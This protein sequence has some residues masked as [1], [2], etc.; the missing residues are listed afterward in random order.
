MRKA[1]C[2]C[3]TRNY[4]EKVIPSLN[5]MLY[6][7]KIDT[8][9]IL[10]EDDDMPFPVP[11]CVKVINVSD[12]EYFK[13]TGINY[14]NPWSY[15]VMMRGALADI[16]EDE[17]QVLSID[18]DTIINEDISP[19][20][21]YDLTG[22]YLAGARE[23]ELSCLHCQIY[24][25]FGVVML[26]LKELR[27]MLPSGFAMWEEL[28]WWMNNVQVKYIEQDTHN[29]LCAGKILEI[30]SDWNVTSDPVEEDDWVRTLPTEHVR[31]RHYAGES[32]WWDYPEVEKWK[33]GRVKSDGT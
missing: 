28:V 20:W 30:P 29:K 5:S 31:I 23:L 4:Y 13:K 33:D 27:K 3:L 14:N 19:L 12:Q 25:N 17:D 9:Y 16:L 10:A 11:D 22:Y 32:G 21:D 26:N 7:T 18:A 24:V 2:Y 6:H 8:V 1:V 15:M